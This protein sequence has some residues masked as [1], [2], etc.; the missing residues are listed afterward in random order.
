[1]STSTSPKT[2]H[3]A[4]KLSFL[5]YM[6]EGRFTDWLTANGKIILYTLA[7]IIVVLAAIFHFSNSLM[8]RSEQNYIDAANDFVVFSQGN[9]AKNPAQVD[10]AYKN[11]KQLMIKN[12]E[13]HAAYDG[14]LGQT[15]LNRDLT[16]EAKPYITAS[17]SRTHSDE[18]PFYA[19]FSSTSL[20]I[21]EQHYREALDQAEALQNKMIESLTAGST[22][23]ERSFGDELFAL[24]LL[25]IG[26]L[27][28]QVGD[29]SGEQKTW[30]EWKQY[31]QLEK[32]SS[33]SINVDP[34][35][36]RAVIQRLA[37]GAVSIPDYI[38]H[39]EKS[40]QNK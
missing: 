34:S 9:E 24:N 6:D 18:L 26:I 1:M 25:R 29:K 4:P 21:S 20:L 33:S 40:L 10:E 23:A 11:L 16:S 15:L 8:G 2:E 37:V 13:L 5:D 30:H 22:T 3:P 12:P 35:A 28:G 32:G 31:A 39:R 19:E 14:S 27:Q 7:S 17:L 38:T 36:F